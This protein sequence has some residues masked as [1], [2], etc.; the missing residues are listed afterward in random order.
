M[1]PAGVFFGDGSQVNV[2][3]LEAAAGR[4]SDKDFAK[5]EDHFTGLREAA[6]TTRARSAPG[7]RRTRSP[8]AR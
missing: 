8:R 1:N 5:G 7:G 4:I 2:T 6:S 3:G